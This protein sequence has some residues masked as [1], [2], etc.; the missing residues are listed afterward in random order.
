MNV[1]S[2]YKSGSVAVRKDDN[3]SPGGKPADKRRFFIL[4]N[5]PKPSVVMTVAFATE[6]TRS[7]SYLPSTIIGNEM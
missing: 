7:R 6:S 1:V 5:I 4:L 2:Y 3:S